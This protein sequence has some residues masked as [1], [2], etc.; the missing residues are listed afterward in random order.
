MPI[1]MNAHRRRDRD[2]KNFLSSAEPFLSEIDEMLHGYDGSNQSLLWVPSQPVH[3]LMT[4]IITDTLEAAGY[5]VKVFL[6]ADKTL[7][8]MEIDWSKIR[9]PPT[10]D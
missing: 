1:T 6:Y 7:L 9:L 10:H 4:A 3:P 5:F 2:R 8:R